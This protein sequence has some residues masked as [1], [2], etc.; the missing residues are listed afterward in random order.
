MTRF[1][2]PASLILL[3]FVGCQYS[4]KQPAPAPIAAEVP[5]P[6]PATARVP[7]TYANAQAAVQAWIAGAPICPTTTGFRYDAGRL[8]GRG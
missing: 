4:A 5:T 2:L 1:I 6:T 3:A 8:G 7:L